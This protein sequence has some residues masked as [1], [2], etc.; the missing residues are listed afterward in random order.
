[1]A[2]DRAVANGKGRDPFS[3]G[4]VDNFETLHSSFKCAARSRVPL[5]SHILSRGKMGIRECECPPVT[6]EMRDALPPPVLLS[7]ALGRWLFFSENNFR[8][9]F[10]RAP[11]PVLFPYGRDRM[12]SE[13][14]SGCKFEFVYRPSVVVFRRVAAFPS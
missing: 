12:D 8:F 10:G 13:L 9:I 4:G 3:C 7:V 5:R 1:M 6:L 2:T 14:A 11:E